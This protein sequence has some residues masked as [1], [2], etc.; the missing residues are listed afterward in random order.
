VKADPG[1]LEQVLLNLVVN[2]RDAMPAGGRLDL[3][4][5]N[6]DLDD[7]DAR[8]LGGVPAGPYVVLTVRDTGCGMNEATMA[9]I[10]EPFFTT[11]EVGKGTGL[12]LA[13]VYGIVKQSGGHVAVASEVGVGTTFS[14]YLPR[15]AAA[16]APAPA[17]R[18]EARPARGS[19]TVLVVEDEDAVRSLTCMVLE[20]RGYRVLRARNGAEGLRT[21]E[22][23]AGP[24]DLLITD[25][26]MP[27][28]GG[29]EMA[30]RLLA[31]YPALKV[32]Y[33]SGYTEDAVLCDGIRQAQAL[34]LQ[35]PFS[36]ADLARKAREALDGAAAAA[37]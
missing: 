34:F 21:A 37:K 27:V 14:V 36:P 9:H 17:P 18:A 11:K 8:A 30:E 24:I 6:A 4:A 5:R 7:A 22:R 25:V 28:L 16:P 2:A 20:G 19:E 26:V 35:K 3:E 23:H 10:F 32:L 31:R 13:T 15:V 1:E 12:G 33:V 29:R